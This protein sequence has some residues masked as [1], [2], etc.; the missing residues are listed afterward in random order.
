MP[1]GSHGEKSSRRKQ[2]LQFFVTVSGSKPTGFEPFLFREKS[3]RTLG[4]C[5]FR[6]GSPGQNGSR[7]RLQHMNGVLFVGGKRCHAEPKKPAGKPCR[8]AAFFEKI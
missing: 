3:V 7:E 2:G 6:N 8:L 1:F 4:G 5:P